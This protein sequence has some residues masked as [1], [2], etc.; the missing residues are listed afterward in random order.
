MNRV[1]IAALCVAV[2]PAFVRAEMR[3]IPVAQA[4]VEGALDPASPVWK[5]APAV[6]LSLQRTPPLYPTDQPAT[7]DISSVQIQLL[8]GTGNLFVRLEWQDKTHNAATLETAKRTWQ[9]E[10][11]VK[12]SEATNRFSDACAVMAPADA[13]AAGVSPSLQ[14]GD[15]AHPVQIFFWD[16][17]RGPAVLE[18]KGRETTHRTGQ[19]FPAQSQWA[20]G[21][22]IVTMQLPELP[23]GT[24][25]A[26]AIWNGDQQDRDGRKYFSVW[27]KTK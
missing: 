3:T 10:Q 23:T 19:A 4:S 21:R 13:D 7:L 24:P 9:G 22:W 17:T 6:S 1:A 12:Q 20:D 16:A 25:L 8:R 5:S 15:A 2:S 14:M 27:Y 26:V 18:A 11:L